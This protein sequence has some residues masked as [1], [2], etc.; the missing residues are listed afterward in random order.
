M[1]RERDTE[2]V[3]ADR[4]IG[5]ALSPAILG[6][7]SPLPELRRPGGP[8]AHEGAATWRN[9]AAAWLGNVFGAA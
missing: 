8:Y 3:D 5:D 6:I 1:K 9:L 4:L 7:V 2:A